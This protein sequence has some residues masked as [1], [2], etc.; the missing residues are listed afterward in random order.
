MSVRSST[1]PG[2]FALE[3]LEAR[4]LLSGD[5]AILSVPQSPLSDSILAQE[6]AGLVAIQMPKTYEELRAM[7]SIPP[8]RR[9]PIPRRT[10]DE[11]DRRVLPP[12]PEGR[13]A[14]LGRRRADPRD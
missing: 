6:H 3:P 7:F 11:M 13:R 10:N 12:R 8:D 4:V 9:S 14:T 5:V 1:Q 2:L